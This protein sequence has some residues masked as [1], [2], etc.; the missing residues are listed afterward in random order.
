MK[1]KVPSCF[2]PLFASGVILTF[3]ACGQGGGNT[4]IR[5]APATATSTKIKACAEKNFSVQVRTVRGAEAKVCR[6]VDGK[7]L[8]RPTAALYTAVKKKSGVVIYQEVVVKTVRLESPEAGE[9]AEKTEDDSAARQRNADENEVNEFL[10]KVCRPIARKAFS[11]ALL[12][13]DV[14]FRN[15]INGEL[16]VEPDSSKGHQTGNFEDIFGGT[17]SPAPV[18]VAHASED[19]KIVSKTVS[20]KASKTDRNENAPMNKLSPRPPLARPVGFHAELRLEMIGEGAT[21]EVKIADEFGAF[22]SG[23]IAVLPKPT[24]NQI[25]FCHQVVLRV[26]ENFGITKRRDCVSREEDAKEAKGDKKK[27]KKETG[28]SKAGSVD[29]LDPLKVSDEEILEVVNP[30]CGSK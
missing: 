12:S 22:F 16:Y 4:P 3:V 7:P 2:T 29:S 14:R 20:K 30:I 25:G 15:K 11:R 19:S 26:A 13:G 10:N 5:S 17:L 9:K 6:L 28:L 1:S 27:S 24:D 23:S 8:D 21:R 18:A